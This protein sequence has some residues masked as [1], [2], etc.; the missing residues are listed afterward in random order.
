[1]SLIDEAEKVLGYRFTDEA[2]LCEALT[3]ASIADRR[4]NSNERL[5]FLGDSI[6]G[7]I[8]SEH[9]FARFPDYLEGD[10]TQLKG[11]VVSRRVCARVSEQ[12]DLCALMS[13]GKGMTSRSEIPQSVAADVLEAVIAAIYLD[14]GM[15]AARRFV[16]ERLEEHILEADRSTHQ[17]NFKSALQQ[18]AQKHLPTNPVYVLLD[19]KGPDHSKAF[20]VCVEIGGR[21]YP[22]AWANSKKEAEQQAAMLALESLG[23]AERGEDG[24]VRLIED[25]QSI[26]TD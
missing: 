8:V 25:P 6:L 2:L 13:L 16:L 24:A 21:R 26:S 3:H 18:H 20:E 17:Q 4:V 9:V 23:L 22:G 5:E 11:A 14:G 19:E 10:L 12:I 7:L 1:M 15:E